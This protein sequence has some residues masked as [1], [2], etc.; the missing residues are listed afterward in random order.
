MA[1]LQN[2]A[3]KFMAPDVESGVAALSNV[4]F[5]ENMIAWV[6]DPEGEHAY[7]IATFTWMLFY[8]RNE[9]P[10]KAEILR[11]MVEFGLTEG[12]KMSAKMG[13]VPLPQNVV[14]AVRAA[15]KNIQ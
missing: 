9:D 6:P 3:G 12:Q 15:A 4:Q 11:D 1:S 5:P 13:Y 14:E 2:K 8:K 10:K 7:P